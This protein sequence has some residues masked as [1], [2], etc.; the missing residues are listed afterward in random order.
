MTQNT[1]SWRTTRKWRHLNLKN[2]EEITTKG[3]GLLVQCNN[4]RQYELSKHNAKLFARVYRSWR[5]KRVV[6]KIIN[7]S[8]EG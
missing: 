3:Y 6:D 2:V 5:F 1:F 8:S 7:K 4:G